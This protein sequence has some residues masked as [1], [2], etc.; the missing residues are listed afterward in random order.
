MALAAVTVL[1]I[2]MF[3]GVFGLHRVTPLDGLK[4]VFDIGGEANIPTWWNVA[5]L[6]MVAVAALGASFVGPAPAHGVRRSWWVVAAAATYASIDEAAGLHER[7]AGPVGDLDID[8][9]TYGWLLP[10][11]V[12]ASAGAVVLVVAG[13]R[14][15]QPA[16]GRLGL[17]LASYGGAAVGIEAINGWVRRRGEGSLLYSAGTV[18][19][20]SIEMGACVYAV[21]AIVDACRWSRTAAGVTIS[22]R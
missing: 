2:V 21:M 18:S 9:P 11:V 6:L 1:V 7:L 12:V 3:L 17:A 15:P 13:R 19:E 22:P 14:L 16:A 8:V 4:P 20:E 10:G 5:L